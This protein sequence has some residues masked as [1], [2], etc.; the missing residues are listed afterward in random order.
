MKYNF[1]DDKHPKVSETPPPHR[2][3]DLRRWDVNNNYFQKRLLEQNEKKAD[4]Q[5]AEFLKAPK[6]K[7]PFRAKRDSKNVEK[8]KSEEPPDSEKFETNYMRSEDFFEVVVLV[9]GIEPYSSSTV[10]IH[11]NKNIQRIW[12]LS[13]SILDSQKHGF[14]LSFDFLVLN[15]LRDRPFM[16]KRLNFHLLRCKRVTPTASGTTSW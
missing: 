12:I 6:R 2:V 5:G 13:V 11:Y 9:E 10:R 4:Q 1:G 15:V 14:S 3:L 16:F 8:K 7:N